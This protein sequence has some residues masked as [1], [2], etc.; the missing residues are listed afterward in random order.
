MSRVHMFISM[1]EWLK[2]KEGE[3]AVAFNGMVNPTKV[4]HIDVKEEEILNINEKTFNNITFLE[5][6]IK[7]EK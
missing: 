7:K 6:T 3:E 5:Y 2:Y 1:E 4:L